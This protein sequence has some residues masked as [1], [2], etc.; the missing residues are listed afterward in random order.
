[1]IVTKEEKEAILRAIPTKWSDANTGLF[2]MIG[3]PPYSCEDITNLMTTVKARLT[4]AFDA[5]EVNE[6]TGVEPEPD[7]G[8]WEVQIKGKPCSGTWEISVIRQGNLH[9]HESWG[10]IDENK[11]LISHNGSP[12][13]WPLIRPVWDRMVQTAQEVCQEL[14]T[15]EGR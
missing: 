13:H 7:L 5:G 9:G 14:N 12:C 2:T 10:W 3:F 6:S 8:P 4:A 15:A 1:M 11:L